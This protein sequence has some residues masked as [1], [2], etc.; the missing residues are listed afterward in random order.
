MAA[1]SGSLRKVPQKIYRRAIV[2]A[3]VRVKRCG[4][5]APRPEQSGWQG[6][7]H[8]E[9]DQIGEEERPAPLQLPGRSLEPCSNGRPRGMVAAPSAGTETG[10]QTAQVWISRS[11]ADLIQWAHS[12]WVRRSKPSTFP[13]VRPHLCSSSPLPSTILTVETSPLRSAT[14]N[15][16]YISIEHQLGLLRRR[17]LSNLFAVSARGRQAD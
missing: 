10:L 5:S 15:G 16:T 7:P 4:K 2:T 14:S 13:L 11:N 12:S 17:V 6:K 1:Q 3:M 9:Q 8:A